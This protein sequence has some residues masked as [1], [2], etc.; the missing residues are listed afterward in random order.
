MDAF[1]AADQGVPGTGWT[2]GRL[3][4][5]VNAE[6]QVRRGRQ[7]PI[8][9]GRSSGSQSGDRAESRGRFVPERLSEI[10]APH[11]DQVVHSGEN[12]DTTETTA[13]DAL[14]RN[15]IFH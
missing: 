8:P 15:V 7:I 10:R 4:S 9:G 14:I 13:F 5:G 2:R 11:A 6:A 3:G 12:T 1:A